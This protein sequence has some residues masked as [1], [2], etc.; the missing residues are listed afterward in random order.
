MR[1]TPRFLNSYL[2]FKSLFSSS[3]YLQ[4]RNQANRQSI[5]AAMKF[6]VSSILIAFLSVWMGASTANAQQ[7]EKEASHK[8]LPNSPQR[9]VDINSSEGTWLSLDVHPSG[10][11]IIFDYML[12]VASGKKTKAEVLGHDELFNIP[13]VLNYC[14]N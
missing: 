7:M 4:C 9:T 1:C 14:G 10:E 13:R 6:N 11:K 2:H 8:D 5:Y 12:E 3:Y